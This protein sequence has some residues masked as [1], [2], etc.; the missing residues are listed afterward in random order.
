MNDI[1]N[2][3][4]SLP[5]SVDIS[6]APDLMRSVRRLHARRTVRRR[7]GMAAV[8][9]GAVAVSS[10]PGLAISRAR[11][12]GASRLASASAPST[13]YTVASLDA[14]L[15]A[16][17]ASAPAEAAE[18]GR[19]AYVR[20]DAL[21]FVKPDGKGEAKM[22]VPDA[23]VVKPATDGG[24][25]DG[26]SAK[27]P[28]SAADEAAAKAAKAAA[29]AAEGA[30]PTNPDVVVVPKGADPAAGQPKG[31]PADLTAEQKAKL[32]SAP[33]GDEFPFAEVR[34]N[35]LW[36]D[37]AGT[38]W[39]QSKLERNVFLNAADEAKHNARL[40]EKGVGPDPKEEAGGAVKTEDPAL[41]T[42]KLPTD[43][44]AM[45]A[46]LTNV[47]V[48]DKGTDAFRSGLNFL[49]GRVLPLKV[50]IA[51]YRAMLKVPGV[52]VANGVA[53]FAGR[54]GVAIGMVGDRDNDKLYQTIIDPS[55]G[56]L[57]GHKVSLTNE[58]PGF[59]PAG[60]VIEH[61]SIQQEGFVDAIQ[62]RP[63]A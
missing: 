13:A 60:T 41:D 25:K 5:E 32:A 26:N 7:S 48:G 46:Y 9:A 59:G 12:R 14:A 56:A 31:V 58:T 50:R 38:G 8:V 20:F 62:K 47:A 27:P 15:A 22:A 54:P 4:R 17:A 1:E 29:L 35:E 51:V 23:N 44:D 30:S 52:T 53:D 28:Q 39:K 61:S 36:I 3:L 16:L 21:Q 63:A 57:L 49:Q 40:G 19:Y 11:G 43:P 33:Q 18:S 34:L 45:S 55:S 37:H 6:P 24:K 10:V 2:A 42:A